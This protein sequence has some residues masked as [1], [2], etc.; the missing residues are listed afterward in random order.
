MKCFAIIRFNPAPDSVLTLQDVEERSGLH[1]ERAFEDGRAAADEAG[2]DDRE[3]SG[4]SGREALERL[5]MI[6][7]TYLS[8]GTPV[9]C[10]LR[11]SAEIARAGAGPDP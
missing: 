5:E 1:A 7:D 6:A 2:L 9:Q 8:V 11:I 3:R 4:G 10:A